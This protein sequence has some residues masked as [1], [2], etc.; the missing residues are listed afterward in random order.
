M[1]TTYT[2]IINLGLNW[3]QA[4]KMFNAAWDCDEHDLH[5]VRFENNL[6]IEFY[7]DYKAL[8]YNSITD[9]YEEFEMDSEEMEWVRV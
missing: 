7:G 5:I 8:I 2:T 6:E 4:V 3:K 9:V 1:N